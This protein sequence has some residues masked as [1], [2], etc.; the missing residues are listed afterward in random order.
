MIGISADFDPVHKGHVKLIEKGREISEE[1]GDE[2]AVYLNK[3]YSANHGPFFTNYEARREM[4]LKAGADKVVP[5][6]GLHHRLTLSYSVPIRIARMIEDGVVDY[7]DAANVSPK[8]IQKHADKFVKQGI[9]VG[10]PRNLPNRNVIRWF[11]VNEFLYKKYNKNMNFHII[12]ELENNGKISGREIRRSILENNMVI[13]DKTKE[14][15]PKSTVKILEREIK[16]NN[17][18][19]VRNWKDI[20]KRMN[21]YSRGKLEKIAYLSGNAINEIVKG[22]VYRDDE[23]IWATFRRSGYGPV[24]TR[25]AISSIEE[26]VSKKEVMELMRYYESKG[27]IP[28]EQTIDKVIERSWY[29]AS[30][31]EK[32]YSASEANDTFKSQKINM[33]D[34]P[35]TLYAGLNLTKFETKMMKDNLDGEL[36]IDKDGMIAIEI[37]TK[38]KK[39]KTKLRL[40]AK[41][42]TYLRYIMDSHF[43]PLEAKIKEDKKGYKVKINIINN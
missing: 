18:L 29:V 38:G 12:P 27:V 11:A 37:R 41:E 30:E 1:T 21:T 4:A 13:P 43:I 16:N 10:I 19:N 28:P 2:V 31:G 23:S 20:Q 26:E 24:L 22:R 15:L 42:V 25:L 14:L 32:G 36:Y 9:F 39:I 17:I 7:V 34:V 33:P 5:I 35:L 3:G 8:S 40:P 6:E